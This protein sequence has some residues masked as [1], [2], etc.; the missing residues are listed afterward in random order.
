M[1]FKMAVVVVVAAVAVAAVAEEATSTRQQSKEKTLAIL[2]SP[3]RQKS[4]SQA[5]LTPECTN[6]SA[7]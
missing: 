6:I 3:K 5:F 4:V 1:Q 7:M 2:T